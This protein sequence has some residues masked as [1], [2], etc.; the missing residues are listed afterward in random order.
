MWTSLLFLSLAFTQI[1]GQGFQLFF[2]TTQAAK[3]ECKD[4]LP[5]CFAFKKDSCQAP[6][7]KWAQD[8]CPNYCGFCVGPPTPAP[9]CEDTKS[10]C[11]SYQKSVCTDNAYK[12][13]S[14]DNCR[15]YCRLCTPAQL[16]MKDSQVTTL[17]PALCVD[18]LDDCKLYGK[19]SCTGEYSSWA[20]EN[21]RRY[22]GFCVGLP[23]PTPPCRDVIP[24][25]N[26]YQ[27]DTC[28]STKYK[29]WAEENCS[30]YCGFCSDG[31]SSGNQ[32]S[33][34]SAP[35]FAPPFPQ[36][37]GTMAPPF[38]GGKRRNLG[39]GSSASE[40]NNVFFGTDKPKATQKPTQP[41]TTTTEAP[42]T[43]TTPQPTTTTP[44]PTTTTEAP[45]T[46]EPKP[47]DN[48]L[49]IG[50]SAGGQK[51]PNVIDFGNNSELTTTG[52][53]TGSSAGGA[54][55]PPPDNQSTEAPTQEPVK[56]QPPT[57]A[58]V[59]TQ[60]PTQPPT[61]A[62][63]KTQP[64]TQ[65]PVKTQPPTQAP[66]KT[67]PPTQAPVKTQP[68]T[69]TPTKEIPTQPPTKAPVKTQPPTK[70][71]VKTQ[72]P[73]KA[74]VTTQAPPA[75]TQAPTAAAT[76]ATGNNTDSGTG[77]QPNTSKPPMV[78]TTASPVV[79]T[80]GSGMVGST[81]GSGSVSTAGNGTKNGTSA[82]TGS[83]PDSGMTMKVPPTPLASS[84]MKGPTKPQT[85]QAPAPTNPPSSKAPVT[86][87][88]VK[89]NP[90][91]TNPPAPTKPNTTPMPGTLTPPTNTVTYPNINVTDKYSNTDA[92]KTDTECKDLINCRVYPPEK[93]CVNDS[94]YKPWASVRCRAYCGY[95][96]PGSDNITCDHNGQ[97]IRHPKDCH[98]FYECAY[99]I[100]RE[101][102]CPANL[103][104]NDVMKTCDYVGNVPFCKQVESNNDSSDKTIKDLT[105]NT[106]P[107]PCVD[108]IPNCNEYDADLCTNPLYR[109][110]REDN[111]MK[112][113][114]LCKGGSPTAPSAGKRD[115]E[116][117]D[118]TLEFY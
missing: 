58:P 70:A 54:T 17:P 29:G 104:W 56:T 106:S 13:W 100:P 6:Y 23:T 64:P 71:P 110:F 2:G 60:P 117:E 38:P 1:Y 57:Q 41:P 82:G 27:R 81:A 67:Q 87:S 53:G 16:A 34:T 92:N 15:Y 3:T 73:T 105:E 96:I 74:P 107:M 48:A 68:P 4:K 86:S 10:D 19:S 118:E 94:M 98:K 97:L 8:Y 101:L 84:T 99:S 91:K 103:A 61:A 93:I 11:Q 28:T 72:P 39:A 33:V 76:N 49:S 43:T 37:S 102:T 35:T 83:G 20:K 115:Y 47:K 52:S 31:S 88:P 32:P 78:G 113:C 51:Q 75:T 66:V 62:P 12:Q 80:S 69:Q 24:N 114:S 44:Q 18:K 63:V 26:R 116:K 108:K 59:K 111:C 79:T 14:Y 40:G 30:K 22:C 95:C 55:T 42:T 112:F 77:S 89:T 25:C 50:S 90:P 46:P 45:T 36:G 5:N 9:A 21:C 65:A 109:L 85:T 7:L